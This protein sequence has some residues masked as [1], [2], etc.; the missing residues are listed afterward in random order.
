MTR[1]ADSR[2]APAASAAL[3]GLPVAEL[4]LALFDAS[5]DAMLVADAAGIIVVANAAA[6]QLLGYT[7][8]EFVGLSVDALVPDAIRPRHAAYRQGY[9][10]NPRVRPMG[11]ERDLVA[12]HRDG[13]DVMVEIALSPVQLDGTPLVLASVRGVGDYPRV[14]QALKRARYSEHL[15]QLGRLAVDARD[16]QSLLEQLP[17]AAATALQVDVA[18]VALLEPDRQSARIVGGHGLLPG[19]AVGAHVPNTPGSPFAFFLEAHDPIISDYATERRFTIP[20]SFHAAGLTCGMAVPVIDRGRAIGFISLRSRVP[21]RFGDE[22]QRFLLAL[23]NM[24]ASSLQRASSEEALS[25]SQRLES[26]GQLT[27]GIAHDFNNLL[28]VIQGNLQVLEELPAVAGHPYATQLV[29]AAARASRRGADLTSKLLAFSRRQ[30]LQPGV[31][32]VRALLHS[33]ADMLRR[34]VDQRIVIE[35][36]VAPD[37]PLVLADPGQL[38]SALLNIAINARDAMPDGGAL[39]FHAGRCPALP[40]SVRAEVAED[41]A[42]DGFVELAV[43]DTGTGM[44]DSVKERAFEPFFTTKEHGRGTGLGLSTVYGFARQSQGA[45]ALES[46]PGRGTTLRLYL[47]ANAQPSGAEAADMEA[48]IRELPDG[49][50]VLLVEDDFAVRQVVVHFLRALNASVVEAD[51]AEAALEVLAGALEPFDVLL[52][53]IALGPGLRGTELARR[54]QEADP[55]LAVLLMSGF[56]AELLDANGQAHASWELLRKPYTRQELAAALVR[57]LGTA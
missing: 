6:T 16:T 27:G 42:D 47:P 31:V 56:S 24:L 46:A 7:G 51:S 30:V 35:V 20:A 44:P 40:A 21:Q 4:Y 17:P 15:A 19:E 13:H 57:A 34:T 10:T 49:L 54:A 26:V 38:E 9:A 14:K 8:T 43:V 22:E 2:A 33:L 48:A 52:S 11:S 25:H 32:D 55:A 28:T 39:R 29:A 23:S 5:P 50:R 1:P 36:A 3:A 53:D 12:R 18:L 37:C 41:V 45:V